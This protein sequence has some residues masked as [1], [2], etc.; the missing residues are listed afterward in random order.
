MVDAFDQQVCSETPMSNSDSFTAASCLDV[1][2]T[3]KQQNAI[4]KCQN[5][6]LLDK[7]ACKCTCADG[8][9]SPDCSRVCKDDHQRCGMNPG[10]PTKASCSLNNFAI[11]KKYCRKMCRSCNPLIEHTIFNHV[12]CERKLCGDGY[13]LNLKSKPCSCTLL[14]PGPKCDSLEGKGSVLQY[15]FIHIFFQILYFYST[16]KV[17][18]KL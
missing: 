8:W 4:L 10:F 17:N 9:D 6:G 18:F 3:E 1:S 11:A 16:T 12:C 7:K 14:C 5:C 15:C 2:L 13:V